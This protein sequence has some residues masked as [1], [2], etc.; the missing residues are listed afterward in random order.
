MVEEATHWGGIACGL[1]RTAVG[2][3]V[4]SRDFTAL[5]TSLRFGGSGENV[6]D[7]ILSQLMAG[8]LT[9]C[10]GDSSLKISMKCYRDLGGCCVGN[11]QPT[12][13]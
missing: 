6:A 13:P 10:L 11:Q 4:R 1:A 12:K 2:L 8:S 9:V 7:A 5:E 3:T